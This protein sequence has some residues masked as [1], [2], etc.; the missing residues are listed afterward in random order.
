M[1][2]TCGRKKGEREKER[3]E[4]AE[5]RVESIFFPTSPYL[6]FPAHTAPELRFSCQTS[7]MI[8]LLMGVSGSGKTTVGSRLAARLGWPFFDADGFH[9]QANIAKM[10]R[11][12]PLTDADRQ[13]W[14]QAIRDKMSDLKRQGV[15][16]VLTS[17]ALKRDYREMLL[18][19]DERDE[20][21]DE[22]VKLVYLRG[23]Y[24]LLES[25]LETRE[26]H[27][28]K[29]DLLKS[30]FEALQEPKSALVVTVDKSPDA[31]VAEILEALELTPRA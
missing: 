16:A 14:L 5:G 2:L 24:D 28:F 27:F 23:S 7:K 18:G 15:S 25:R 9:P 12:V 29:P 1:K 21:R 30:Q 19:A 26:H 22:K 17:S 6:S 20:E 3:E 4:S 10:A 8:I 13:P 31:V 11:G